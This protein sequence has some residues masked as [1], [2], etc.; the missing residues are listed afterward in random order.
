MP[1]KTRYGSHYHEREGCCGATEPCSSTEGLSPC[2]ICCGEGRGAGRSIE[3]D[4]DV[5]GVTHVTLDGRSGTLYKLDGMM[6]PDD[7]RAISGLDGVS[8]VIVSPE[9]A[10]EIRRTGIFVEDGHRYHVTKASDLSKSGAR[11]VARGMSA[12]APD[13]ATQ[14]VREMRSEDEPSTTGVTPTP[15]MTELEREERVSEIKS[16]TYLA[17][18]RDCD[19]AYLAGRIEHGMDGLLASCDVTPLAEGEKDDYTQVLVEQY[20]LFVAAREAGIGG[21]E[22]DYCASNALTGM[23]GFRI[24]LRECPETDEILAKMRDGIASTALYKDRE[25]GALSEAGIPIYRGTD[26]A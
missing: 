6:D 24:R 21:S 13:V 17:M 25:M 5:I 2:S 20:I 10:P 7:R 4:C 19:V 23:R 15:E 9:Y 3:T 18:L 16:A 1:Y 22:S 8:T 14:D 12:P 26:G 11:G